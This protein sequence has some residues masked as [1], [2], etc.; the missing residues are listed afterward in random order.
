MRHVLLT[1]PDELSEES[2][3]FGVSFITHGLGSLFDGG[4]DGLVVA[5][6]RLDTMGILENDGARVGAM[7]C[8]INF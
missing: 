7:V 2:G 8:R 6:G 5:G 3:R 1:Y 4:E